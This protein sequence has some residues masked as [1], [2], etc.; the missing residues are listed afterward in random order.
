MDSRPVAHHARI[1]GV[2]L[3]TPQL[4]TER[5]T[6]RPFHDDDADEL[7]ALQS[8]ADVLRYWDSP[9]W[10]E[11]ESAER[12]LARCHQVAQEGTGARLVIERSS[13]QEFLG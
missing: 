5:L 4:Q 11:R 1:A 8:S 9:P 3:P 2:R 7:F 6:L 13:G 12:F 10:T